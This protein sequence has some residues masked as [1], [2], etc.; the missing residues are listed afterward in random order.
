MERVEK[1]TSFTKT[2]GGNVTSKAFRWF[3][4]HFVGAI[5][6]KDQEFKK[7]VYR[8]KKLSK[9]CSMNNEAF[10]LVLIRKKGYLEIILLLVLEILNQKLQ[11][12]V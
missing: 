6:P 10:A 1:N 11:F 9:F 7:K 3:M 4:K 12:C 8:N 2:A 5:G